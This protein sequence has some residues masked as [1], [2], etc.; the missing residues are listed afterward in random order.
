MKLK[1]Y[2]KWCESSD[3]YNDN[4]PKYANEIIVS[5]KLAGWG[6]SH[7]YVYSEKANRHYCQ[8][9]HRSDNVIELKKIFKRCNE[10]FLKRMKCEFR[11]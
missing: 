8:I 4:Y 1:V 2:V 6:N 11:I 7:V 9:K 3:N 5:E 10:R